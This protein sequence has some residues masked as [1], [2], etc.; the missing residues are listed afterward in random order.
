[1]F[2][3]IFNASLKN[4]CFQKHFYHVEE[5]CFQKNLCAL[6]LPKRAEFLPK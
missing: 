6:F 2:S 4:T 1:M 3:K 5:I